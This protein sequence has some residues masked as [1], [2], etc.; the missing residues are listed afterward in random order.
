MDYRTTVKKSNGAVTEVPPKKQV[1]AVVASGTV[2]TKEK[3][4]FQKFMSR[5]VS[6]DMDDIGNYILS[7]VLIPAGKKLIVDVVDSLV[8]PGGRDRRERGGYGPN[9]VSFR[10][11]RKEQEENN[12]VRRS[13]Y[14]QSVLDYDS[15][16]FNSRIEAE[17]VL[18]KMLEILETYGLVSIADMYDLA[19]VSHSFTYDKYGWYDLRTADVCRCNEGYYIKTPKVVSLD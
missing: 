15:L 4:G 1:E 16:I 6:D 18:A 17:T 9:V 3:T 13:S 5:F 12:R 2:K 11:Y 10:N 14:T 7:D 19:G 8:Y